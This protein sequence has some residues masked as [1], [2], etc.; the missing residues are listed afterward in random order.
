MFVLSRNGPLLATGLKRDFTAFVLY[1]KQ[2]HLLI[3]FSNLVKP[4][5]PLSQ[6]KLY[7]TLYSTDERNLFARSYENALRAQLGVFVGRW[8]STLDRVASA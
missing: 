8:P 6:V 7:G 3:Y 5:N 4:A 2:K 1:C